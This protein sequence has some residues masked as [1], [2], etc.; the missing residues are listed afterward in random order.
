MDSIS[1]LLSLL[2]SD[3][4]L[5]VATI[6]AT[7]GSTPVGALSKMLIHGDGTRA[8]G[9]VGGGCMEGDVLEAARKLHQ[10]NT[11]AILT[12]HLNED[13]VIQGLICGGNLDILVEPVDAH[14][15]E[16]YEK[17]KSI[18]DRGEDCV[19]ATHLALD[20]RVLY[21]AVVTRDELQGSNEVLEYWRTIGGATTV[22]LGAILPKVFQ[23]S[24]GERLQIENGV[25]ILE[26]VLGRPHL[27]VF[28]GGHVSL[29]VTRVAAMAGFRVTVVDD[30]IQFA[31]KERFPEAE[32]TIAAEFY[33]AMEKLSITTSTYA[34]IVTRGHRSDEEILGRVVK[35]QAKY[36]GMIGSKRKVLATFKNLMK[37]GVSQDLLE[38]VRAPMGLDIGAATAEEIAV[39]IVA[40]MIQVRRGAALPVQ[41][42]SREM[43]TL[44][45]KQ[46]TS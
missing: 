2:T 18:R 27:I 16:L 45:Q 15:R 35:T 19:V 37:D 22:D 41:L 43:A 9:T 13:E 1:H 6:I 7:S 17:L 33:D 12:F 21:K 44:L 5:M 31:N 20:G 29:Y 42:K 39:S 34:V 3:S 30:R 28:G 4:R 8:T 46:E 40:E 25:M 36:V 14:Q 11:A 10:D 23:R 32:E 26:P 38:K 24:Q